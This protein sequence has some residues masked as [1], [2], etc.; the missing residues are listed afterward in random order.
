MINPDFSDSLQ[1]SETKTYA[2]NLELVTDMTATFMD[3]L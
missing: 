2:K 3:V 1:R